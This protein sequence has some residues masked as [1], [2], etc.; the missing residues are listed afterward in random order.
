MHIGMDIHKRYAQVAVL[1]ENG[2]F[3]EETRVHPYSDK[4]QNRV[5]AV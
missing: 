3:L 2:Q 5:T 4:R 1:D